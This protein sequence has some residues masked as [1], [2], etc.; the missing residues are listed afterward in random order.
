LRNVFSEFGG[1]V[2]PPRLQTA[3]WRGV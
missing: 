2:R 3:R 1:Q